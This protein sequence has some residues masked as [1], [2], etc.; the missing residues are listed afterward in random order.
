MVELSPLLIALTIFH[1]ETLSF[2]NTFGKKS[3]YSRMVFAIGGHK[4]IEI[5]IVFNN[6]KF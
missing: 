1:D 4:V 6:N 5:V 2:G 3:Q